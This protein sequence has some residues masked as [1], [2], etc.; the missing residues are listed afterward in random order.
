MPELEI[1]TIGH[2]RAPLQFA[3]YSLSAL[4]K[5]RPQIIGECVTICVCDVSA[6]IE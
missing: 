4:L 1:T 6:T 3:N 5:A 2:N